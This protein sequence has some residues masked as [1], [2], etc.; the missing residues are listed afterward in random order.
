MQ[1][2]AEEGLAESRHRD[3]ARE[4]GCNRGDDR[5]RRWSGRE[6]DQREHLP[7]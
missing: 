7:A 4:K 5:E 3:E 2:S 1:Q 6:Q